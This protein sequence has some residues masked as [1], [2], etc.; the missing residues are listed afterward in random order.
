MVQG[1]VLYEFGDQNGVMAQD[2]FDPLGSGIAAPEP[3]DFGRSPKEPAA[4]CEIAVL[5]YDAVA[6]RFCVLPDLTVRRVIKI[7]AANMCRSGKEI[8]QP[9][10]QSMAQVLI[11]KKPH[12][13][14]PTR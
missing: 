8:S 13:A 2:G 3:D 12:A 10:G 5:G 9:H 14:E 11:E 4:L 7:G 1:R 6:V